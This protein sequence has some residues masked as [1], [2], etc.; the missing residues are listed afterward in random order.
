MK[1]KLIVALALATFSALQAQA[2]K[3]RAQPKNTAQ[4]VSERAEVQNG[5]NP[6]KETS[7]PQNGIQIQA[8][9]PLDQADIGKLSEAFG[10]FIGRNLKAPGINFD[11]EKI[12]K[13]IRDGHGGKPAIMSDQEYEMMM[14]NL[15]AQVFE[16]LSS[17]N[18]KAANQFMSQNSKAKGVFEVEPGKLQYLILKEGSGAAVSATGTPMIHYKGTYID[19][20]QFDSSEA[21][22]APVKIPLQQTIP[23]FGKGI[24]GMKEGEKR[25]IFIHP[26]LGYGQNSPLPPNAL[27]IFEVELIKAEAP[28]EEAPKK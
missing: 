28:V 5:A 4:T 12:I 15:Q 19:G 25:K 11:L 2:V 9:K 18:M 24:A 3:E 21:A 27:L 1:R 13:G 7:Q 22:G 23:G 8:V 6:V 26:D 17:D 16:Q 10:H 20:T 14:A